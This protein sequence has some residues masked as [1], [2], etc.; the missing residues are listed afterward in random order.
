MPSSLFSI[1]QPALS[2]PRRKSDPEYWKF[3]NAPVDLHLDSNMDPRDRD[4]S[5]TPDSSDIQIKQRL[6]RRAFYL[7]ARSKAE[8]RTFVAEYGIISSSENINEA[9][10]IHT[11]DTVRER[12]TV[13]DLLKLKH[14]NAD[15]EKSGLI[16][17]LELAD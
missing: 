11:V 1:M 5:I 8:L 9:Q 4:S 7:R 14:P 2:T 12:L 6:A 13:Q 15:R 10:A 16:H 3:S 17:T